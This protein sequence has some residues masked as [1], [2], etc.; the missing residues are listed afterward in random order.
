MRPWRVEFSPAVAKVVRHLPP[1][2]KALV[3]EAVRAIVSDPE[4]GDA[5]QGELEGLRK[6]RVRRYRI[7]YAVNA[8]RRRIEIHAVGHRRSVYDEIAE[9][10]KR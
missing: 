3:R 8:R 4:L 7:V 9:I 10:K 5:L 1:E 6:F 2:I